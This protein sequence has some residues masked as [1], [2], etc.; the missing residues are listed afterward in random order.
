MRFSRRTLLLAA[1]A[2]QNAPFSTDV[3]VVTLLA[4]VRDRDGTTIK[5]LNLEDF[6]LEEDGRP[7]TIRYFR[8]KPI[9]R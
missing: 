1:F 9:G 8:P 3:R 4:T 2:R 7:L 6:T 5:N